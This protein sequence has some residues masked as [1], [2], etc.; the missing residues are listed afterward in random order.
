MR[1]FFASPGL[2]CL[3]DLPWMPLY[4]AI[5]FLIHSYLGLLALGGAVFVTVLAWVNEFSIRKALSQAMVLELSETRFADQSHRH[6]ESTVPMGILGH[7]ADH[8]QELHSQGVERAQAGGERAELFAA[9]S[10]ASRLLLQ[11]AILGL[12]AW[13][14]IRQEITPGT[15]VATSVIAG[16]ALAPIDQLIGQ[17]RSI[18]RARQSYRRLKG[19]LGSAS[20]PSTPLILPEPEGHLQV[21]IASHFAPGE[22]VA[23]GDKRRA[24]LSREFRSGAGRRFGGHRAKCGGEIDACSVAYRGLGA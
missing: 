21:R 6:A 9:I 4:L 23:P 16:R 24:I 1:S 7:I 12:G 2:L 3:F 15:I 14:A 18:L 20:V 10:K 5:A 11:S 17:W 8:W 19:H 13:L 22:R